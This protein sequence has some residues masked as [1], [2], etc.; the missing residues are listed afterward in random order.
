MRIREFFRRI[1]VWFQFPK[2]EKCKKCFVNCEYFEV[3]EK[4]FE[5]QIN[6]QKNFMRKEKEN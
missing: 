3:C 2:E 4:D 5:F 6:P 1:W